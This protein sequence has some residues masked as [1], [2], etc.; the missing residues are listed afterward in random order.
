VGNCPG[1]DQDRVNFHQNPER[2]TAEWADPAWPNR[3]GYSVPWTVMLGSGLGELGGGSSLAARE[4]PVLVRSGRVALWFVRFVSCFLL[5]CIIVVT[6]PFAVLVNCPCP[7]PP[8]SACFF[9]FFSA[10]GGGVGL[11]CGAFVAGRSQ[12]ITGMQT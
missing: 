6:V 3:T 11:P 9:P 2:G 8:V 5:I 10:P 4:R 7:D 1:F 12:T